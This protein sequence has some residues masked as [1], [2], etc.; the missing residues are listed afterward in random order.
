MEWARVNDKNIKH[1]LPISSEILWPSKSAQTLTVKLYKKEEV[2]ISRKRAD[3]E[4]KS[5]QVIPF[6]FSFPFLKKM[7]TEI[8]I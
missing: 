8:C 3:L 6:K 4:I 1:F 2:I 5:S 7:F